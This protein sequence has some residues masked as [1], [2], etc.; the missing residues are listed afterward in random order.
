M[1]YTG[2]RITNSVSG[3]TITF[4]QT[5]ADTDGELLEVELLLDPDGKVPGAH[6]HPEQ[7]ETFHVLEGRM[8]F[9]CGVRTI[10]ARPGDTVVVPRGKVHRFANDGD[11]TA[12]LRVEV[13]PALEMEELFETTVALAEAGRTFKS[14]LPKPIDLALFVHRFRREVRGPFAPGWVQRASLAPLAALGRRRERRASL[15]LKPVV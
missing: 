11:T 14:G 3:E 12:R 13:R 4:L 9:Q 10:T 15:V 6:V 2:Q 7:E 8:K 5:A 1:A